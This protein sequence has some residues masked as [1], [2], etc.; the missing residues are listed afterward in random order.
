M[1]VKEVEKLDEETRKAVGRVAA[2]YKYAL[3]FKKE[4][5]QIEQ[6]NP[7]DALRDIKKGISILRWV[8]RAERRVDQSERKILSTLEDLGEVLPENLKT[9]SEELSKELS[10]AEAKLVHLAS[11]FRGKVKQELE[12]IKTD[13]ALL[14][15]YHDNPSQAE[16][17][18]THLQGL[19]HSA[20]GHVD[21][22]LQWIGTTQAV[23]KKVIGFEETLQRLSA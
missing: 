2:E 12:D 1:S 8:G 9:E 14:Q 18:H 21:E 7:E 22:M 17:L 15:K 20:K 11:M 13:E 23:L 10:V 19:F 6:D 4:L 16:H 5:Q 3:D